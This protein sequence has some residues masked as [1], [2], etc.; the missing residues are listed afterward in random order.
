MNDVWN[1]FINVYLNDF[2][3]AFVSCD[4]VVKVL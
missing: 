1:V 4:S 2:N 3:A